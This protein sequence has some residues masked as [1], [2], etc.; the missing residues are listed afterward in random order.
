M[1]E[2]GQL[3]RVPRRGMPGNSLWVQK[4]GDRTRPESKQE[5][6]G[7]TGKGA[8]CPRE[9]ATGGHVGPVYKPGV[10]PDTC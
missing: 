6:E 5:V 4:L 8:L 3:A 1:G 7:S 9:E 2:S 10:S